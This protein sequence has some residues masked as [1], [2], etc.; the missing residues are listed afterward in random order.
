MISIYYT[1]ST[2]NNENYYLENNLV[3][4]TC[5]RT[6]PVP[7]LRCHGG[8]VSRHYQIQEYFYKK[9]TVFAYKEN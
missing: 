1:I 7:P 5:H 4:Y 6:V 8:E 3:T 2:N 9:S